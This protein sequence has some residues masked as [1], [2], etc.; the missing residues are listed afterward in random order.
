MNGLLLDKVVDNMYYI[1]SEPNMSGNYGNPQNYNFY[2][3]VLLP[4]ELVEEYIN[5]RGF[6]FLETTNGKVVG[7]EVNEDALL[8]YLEEHPD[9]QEVS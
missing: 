6:V 7:L 2:Q 8:A 4:D 1:S 5:A 3:S 9:E